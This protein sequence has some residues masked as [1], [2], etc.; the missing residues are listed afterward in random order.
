MEK[1]KEAEEANQFKSEFLANMSH[2][3]RTPLNVIIGFSQ[4]MMDGVPGK[5]NAEQKQCLNDVLDSSQHLLDLINEVLDLSRIE[6]GKM[7]LRLKNVALTEVIQSLSRTMRPI[8]A[9]RKQSLDVEIEEGLPPVYADEARLGQVLLNLVHN[10]AKFTPDEGKLKIEAVGE[11]DWCRVSVI[12]NGVGIKEEDK[13]RIFEPFCQLGNP[14]TEER[15]GVGLGLTLVKQIVERYGG[16]IWVESEYGKGS[17]FTFTVP[18][19]TDG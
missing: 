19:A 16:R 6:S 7:A 4:L 15:N 17:R 12:D 11:G 8:L 1:T 14:L 3:L 18:L 9:P 2:E 10:A 13:E 5:I